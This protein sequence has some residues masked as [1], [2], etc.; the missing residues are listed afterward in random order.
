MQGQRHEVVLQKWE[1]YGLPD[2]GA[3]MELRYLPEAPHKPMTPARYNDAGVSEYLPWGIGV[4]VGY[5]VLQFAT[6]VLGWA[7]RRSSTKP[8]EEA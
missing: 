5:F 4:F 1:V 7:W 2:I 3:K 6:G 8:G